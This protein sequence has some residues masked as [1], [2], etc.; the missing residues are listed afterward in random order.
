MDPTITVTT[1][2]GTTNQKW[3]IQVSQIACDSYYKAPVGC[4]QYFLENSGTVR[5][6]NTQDANAMQE[7][8][9]QN[10]RICIRQNEGMCGVIL[11]SEGFNVGAAAGGTMAG[12]ELC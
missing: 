1:V 11:T 10:M 8:S 12:N 9:S 4:T 7:L 6:Y 3:N 5:S 2:A